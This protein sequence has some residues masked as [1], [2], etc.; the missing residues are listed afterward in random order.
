MKWNPFG[1]LKQYNWETTVGGTGLMTYILRNL[2][3]RITFVGNGELP[4]LSTAMNAVTISEDA[5]GRV[6]SRV[7]NPHD[8]T[9]TGLFDS[10]YLYDQQDRVTCETTSSQSACPTT[11]AGIKNNQTSV[12]TN[13]GDW[14][15]DLRPIPGSTGLTK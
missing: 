2:A 11:G 15:N 10:Y 3:Y 4:D 13:A 6:V 12:F 7:Y 8:P 1:P 5:K 9:T 14:L